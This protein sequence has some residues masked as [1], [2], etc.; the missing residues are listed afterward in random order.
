ME[1]N[2]LEANQSYLEMLGYTAGEILGLRYQDVTP[3]KWHEFEASIIAQQVLPLGYSDTYEKEHIRKDGAIFPIELRTYLIKD[4][5]GA[6]AGMW[7]FIRDIT[8]RK[9]AEEALREQEQQYRSIFESVSDGLLIVDRDGRVVEANPAV[10]AMHGYTREEM[11]GLSGSDFVHPDFLEKFREACNIVPGMIISAEPL[12]IRKDGSLL[13]LQVRGSTLEFRGKTHLLGVVTDITERKQAEEALRQS[14]LRFR[15]VV[16]F[17]P[18]P[19]GLATADGKIEYVNPKFVETFGYSLEDVSQLA[20]WYRLAYPDP[21]YRQQVVSRW[22]EGLEKIALGISTTEVTEVEVAC[23]DGSK[24]TMEIFGALLGNKTMALFNDL[25]ERKQ[26]EEVL[27]T[28]EV[29]YREI[30]NTVSETIWI[31][32]IETWKFIDVN[33]NV[34]EMF[35]Y[36]VREAM[37]LTVEDI[38]SGVYPFVK[39]TAAE[40]LKKAAA[41]EPQVFEWQCKHKD[42]HL[43]WSEVNLKRGTIAGKDCILAL[44]RNI[45]ERKQA[46]EALQE[47]EKK[48]R[49]L[50]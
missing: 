25:T 33:K 19:I 15:Q 46:E 30:F 18:L 28:S 1:G 24:R 35:G 13:P 12:D 20:D 41:G 48:Y 39:A 43:F 11:I 23:K 36:S 45:T 26:A 5:S 49:S 17:S 7:A 10:C 29:T 38:S 34:M 14:E 2:I 47:S 37:D 40:L 27:R 8:H 44:E 21:A 31:H 22:Q 42:G 9:R 6:P 32:D 4:K 50:Y 3:P 16:E